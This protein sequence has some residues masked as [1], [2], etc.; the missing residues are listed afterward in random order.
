MRDR[1]SIFWRLSGALSVALTLSAC[2]G[3]GD[4]NNPGGGQDPMGGPFGANNLFGNPVVNLIPDQNQTAP[5]QMP[6]AAAHNVAAE[7]FGGNSNNE[8]EIR[9]APGEGTCVSITRWK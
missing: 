9:T 7:H 2:G 4:P 6:G 5:S 1:C 3:S 8:F